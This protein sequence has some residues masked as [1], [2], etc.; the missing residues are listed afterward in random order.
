MLLV[1][2]MLLLLSSLSLT[3]LHERVEVSFL[4]WCI[5]LGHHILF[6]SFFLLLLFAPV[7]GIS[8]CQKVCVGYKV[9][10]LGVYG[11]AFMIPTLLSRVCFF[12]F[13]I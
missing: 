11:N 7:G 13:N 3:S 4:V 10:C 2:I 8:F 1:T 5:A 9:G 6:F 12:Y